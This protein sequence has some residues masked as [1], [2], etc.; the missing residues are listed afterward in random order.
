VHL[1]VVALVLVELSLLAVFAFPVQSQGLL[2]EAL[3]VEID[4]STAVI[5]PVAGPGSTWIATSASDLNEL[6]ADFDDPRWHEALLEAQDSSDTATGSSD[7]ISREVM[8][9]IAA[10]EARTEDENLKRL[11]S[12]SDSLTATSSAES[13]DQL[14]TSLRRWLGTEERATRPADEPVAGEFDL[15]TAQLHDVV[16]DDS[17]GEI[18]YTAVLLDAAGRTMESPLT[19]AE[20]ESV[21][22]VMQLMKDN[23][24][25][26]RVYRGVVLSFLDKLLRQQSQ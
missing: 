18:R 4:A 6:V 3:P 26:E 7:F 23:P 8:Q 24:L 9:A 21:Y 13:I 16:R 15:Q 12:L 1:I 11:E 5:E 2:I 14:T 19:E 25:L 22:R 10:A 17:S 20:G